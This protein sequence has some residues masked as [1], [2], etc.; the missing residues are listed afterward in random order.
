MKCPY[1]SYIDGWC[2]DTLK[3]IE[4]EEGGFFI[5]SNSIVMEKHNNEEK[6]CRIYGCPVCNKIF[7]GR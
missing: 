1:C 6:R 4:G 3:N 7:M 2:S 5:A